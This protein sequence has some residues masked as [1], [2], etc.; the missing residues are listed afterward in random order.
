MNLYYR[1][2]SKDFKKGRVNIRERIEKLKMKVEK[3]KETSDT[4]DDRR[5]DS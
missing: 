3:I 1:I 4:S 2:A 5:G